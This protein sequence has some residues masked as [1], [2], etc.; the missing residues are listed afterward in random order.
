M[1]KI[2]YYMSSVSTWSYIG[3]AAFCDMARRHGVEVAI[4]PVD[5]G[6]VFD[7]SGALPLAKR[8]P[9]RQRYRFLEMQRFVEAR[10]VSLKLKPKFF[11][12]D[13]TLADHTII[14]V[15]EAGGDA[16]A[17]AGEVM[18][19]VWAHD[20]DVSDE[21]V[22]ADTIRNAGQ[23]PQAILAAARTPQI[24]EIRKRNTADAIAAD[25]IGAPVYV[26]NGEPYWGQDRIELLEAAIVSGRAPYKPV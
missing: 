11:P 1:V 15:G 3:H 14:A 12:V 9:A 19:N 22:L 23:D 7:N 16:L 25:A 4:R 5:L 26:L 8:S 17:Y 10:G 20:R 21:N 6:A 24:A 18:A 13:A 2:D